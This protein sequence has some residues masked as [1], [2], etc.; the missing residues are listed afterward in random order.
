MGDSGEKL[1]FLPAFQ[2]L[3]YQIV[4][5]WLEENGYPNDLHKL[6]NNL[7]N[8]VEQEKA[9]MIFF[10][11]IRN[12]ISLDTIEK[13][14]KKCITINWFCD[15]QWRFE[16]FTKFI[17]PKLTYSI[18]V[19]KYSLAKYKA[20]GCQNVILS[21]WAAFEYPENINSNKRDYKYDISFVGEKTL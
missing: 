18:T 16:A 14:T 10:V 3:G 19:D 13:L 11:L 4:P 21:Q 2:K 6:Q 9:D 8:F 7:L 5:F 1:V 17:A 12:E 20:I 15:D